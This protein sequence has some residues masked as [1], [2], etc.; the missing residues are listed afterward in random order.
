MSLRKILN[1]FVFDSSFGRYP[2]AKL[3]ESFSPDQIETVNDGAKYLVAYVLFSQKKS[4]EEARYNF[5]K[6]YR[7]L[8]LK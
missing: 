8:K 4:R 1:P 6:L 5:A 3:F 2:I 7:V